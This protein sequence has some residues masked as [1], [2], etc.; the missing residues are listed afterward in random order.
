M[1]D[2]RESLT[3]SR[4][5]TEAE[6]KEVLALTPKDIDNDLFVRFFANRYNNDARFN[7]HD[8]FTLKAGTLFNEKTLVTTVGRYVFNLFVLEYDLLKLVGYQNYSMTGDGLSDLTGLLDRLLLTDVIDGKRYA[9]Y[10]NKLDFMYP[11]VKFI[12]PS[13]TLDLIKPTPKANAL[14]EELLKDPK[15]VKAINDNDIAVMGKIE[16]QVL[17]VGVQEAKDIPDFE[18]YQSGATGKINNSYKNTSY[19]R[20]AIRN[21][22]DNDKYFVSTSSL[23]EGIKP[24]EMDKYAEIAVQAA[25]SRAIDTRQGGYEYKKIASALQG[26]VADV[27]GSDCGTKRTKELKVDGATKKIILYRYIVENGKLVQ[28]N[29][30]NINN[31]VGKTVHMRSPMYCTGNKYC[32]ICSGDLFYNMDLDNIGLIANRIGT[33]KSM[34]RQGVI[35]GCNSVNCWKFLRAY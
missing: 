4:E 19:F 29:P 17:D 8:Y 27:K 26:V 12:S 16:K 6:I 7:T 31:Y 20:G 35:L 34:A 18:I 21:V 9:N 25:S 30:E 23:L 22:A 5:L 10:L 24:E 2:K 3:K 13:L 14:K 1:S 15:N 33:A 32:N 11:L 28:L